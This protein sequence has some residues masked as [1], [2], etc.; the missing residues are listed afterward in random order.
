MFS[1]IKR[2]DC[3]VPLKIAE[4]LLSLC[5]LSS[6]WFG[7]AFFFGG[8]HLIFFRWGSEWKSVQCPVHE[9]LNIL[10]ERLEFLLFCG[11]FHKTLY[12]LP[13]RI[14]V[15]VE[16]KEFLFPL[17]TDTH[18]H[19]RYGLFLFHITKITIIVLPLIYRTSFSLLASSNFHTHLYYFHC[20][21]NNRICE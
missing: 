3:S 16:G 21:C 18:Y 19:G 6:L 8:L 12:I 5:Y 17:R 20:I 13:Y 15:E 4:L 9:D 2:T 1:T 14:G 10:K 7:G 11:H